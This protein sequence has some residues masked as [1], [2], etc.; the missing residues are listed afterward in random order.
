MFRRIISEGPSLDR[1]PD[2]VTWQARPS[3]LHPLLPPIT[4]RIT[5]YVSN[6]R[7][8][9]RIEATLRGLEHGG[10]LAD[11]LTAQQKKLLSARLA[12]E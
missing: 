7:T 10:V 2:G 3:L 11:F 6:H 4:R 8:D 12:R 9:L 5:S 1:V